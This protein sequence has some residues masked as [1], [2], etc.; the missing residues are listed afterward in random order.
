MLNKLGAIYSWEENLLKYDSYNRKSRSDMRG[1][2]RRTNLILNILIGVVLLLIIIVSSIIFFG[3]NDDNASDKKQDNQIES[4]QE[5]A[6]G[7][8]VDRDEDDNIVEEEDK[9]TAA[10]TEEEQE[11]ENQSD[12]SDENN[13]LTQNP[14]PADKEDEIVTSGGENENVKRTIENPSWQPIGTSQVG[15]HTSVFDPDS[16]DWAEMIQAITYATGVEEN[17]MNIWFIGNNGHNRAIGTISSK[18]KQEKY[19]VFIDWVD[20]QGWKPTKVE[21]LF[22]IEKKPE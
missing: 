6:A 7:D 2:R 5:S 10:T 9:E 13:S 18:D 8:D 14:T 11:N 22:E 16:V 15:E 12:E 20:G 4:K 1:K 3:G 21:E 19:R 17:N